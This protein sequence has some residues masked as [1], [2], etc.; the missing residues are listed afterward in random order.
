M[1]QSTTIYVECSPEPKSNDK[2][3]MVII[4]KDGGEWA[5]DSSI[6]LRWLFEDCEEEIINGKTLYDAKLKKKKEEAIVK[7]TLKK[8]LDE[9]LAVQAKAKLSKEELAALKRT[10]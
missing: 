5:W 9:T 6:P 1:I 7:K 2:Y 3:E 8:K 10:L 4:T